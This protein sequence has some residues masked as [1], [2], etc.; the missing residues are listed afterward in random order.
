ME[1]SSQKGGSEEEGSEQEAKAEQDAQLEQDRAEDK[2]LSEVAGSAAEDAQPEGPPEKKFK[3]SQYD[4]ARSQFVGTEREWC[5]SELR[6][7]LIAST[8]KQE[9]CR[10]RFQKHRPDLFG[11]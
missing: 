3:R 10:R 6:M 2:A 4:E 5:R 7:Q 1:D 9:I 8:G 11:T